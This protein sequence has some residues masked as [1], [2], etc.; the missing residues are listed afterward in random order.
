[1]E[2]PRLG[3]KLKLW[4][5]AYAKPQQCQTQAACVTCRTPHGNARSLTHWVRPGIEPTSSWIL[6]RFVSAEPQWE[7][8]GIIFLIYLSDIVLWV[9]RNATYLCILILYPATL[10]NLLMRFHSFLVASLRFSIYN[11]TSSAN[12]DSFNFFLSSL[13]SFYLFFFT[14]LYG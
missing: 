2:V 4:L 14:D 10:P 5:P 11:I 1:M 12:N 7:F 8:S 13:D 9:Y 6:V 3:V